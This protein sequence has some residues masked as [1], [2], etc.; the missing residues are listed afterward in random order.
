MEDYFSIIDCTKKDIT[1]ISPDEIYQ[2]INKI[3][4][5]KYKRYS[6]KHVDLCNKDLTQLK[7]Y[8]KELKDMIIKIDAYL[9]K[10]TQYE[11][12]LNYLSMKKNIDNKL[13]NIKLKKRK[14][15]NEK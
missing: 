1:V 9:E 6:W 11:S 3:L 8:Q 7:D 14:M 13:A 15:K 2:K 12:K 10:S 4:D 5:F